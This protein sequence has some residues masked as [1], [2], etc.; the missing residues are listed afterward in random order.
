MDAAQSFGDTAKTA[1][2][3]QPH[4]DHCVKLLLPHDRVLKDGLF[5]HLV[6]NHIMHCNQPEAI[7]FE[8]AKF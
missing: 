3:V 2:S 7:V 6:G 5:R 1:Y 4:R 8:P